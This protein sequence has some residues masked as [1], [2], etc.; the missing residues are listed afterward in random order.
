MN[1]VHVVQGVHDCDGKEEM[2]NF[3][4]LCNAKLCKLYELWSDRSGVSVHFY[5]SPFHLGFLSLARMQ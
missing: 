2:T 1:F 4:R 5:Y 3:F